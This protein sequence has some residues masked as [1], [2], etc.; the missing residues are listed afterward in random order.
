MTKKINLGCGPVGK[1]DWINIDWGILAILHKYSLIEKILLKFNLF[2]KGYNVQWPKNLKLHNCRRKLPFTSNSIDYIYA[3]HLLEHFKKFEAERII[4]DCFRILRKGG[5]M[6]VVVPDLESLVKKY[7]EKDVDYFKK[8]NDLMNFNKKKEG[9][10]DTFLLADIL[11]DTFYP[12]FYKTKPAGI[13]KL[14]T[15]FIR[16][17]CWMYDCESLKHLLKNAGFKNVQ[18]RSF[19]EGRVPDLDIL[20]VFPEMSLYVEAEK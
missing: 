2:P 12:H 19:G 5:L 20:D 1:E 15:F 14:M 11:M 9:N 3:S 8:L 13:K 16:P 6:R 4:N 17:H 10:A 18:R 7:L